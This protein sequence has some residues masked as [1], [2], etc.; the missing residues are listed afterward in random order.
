LKVDKV[1]FKLDEKILMDSRIHP[2]LVKKRPENSLILP[3]VEK[4][5]LDENLPEDRLFYNV[6]NSHLTKLRHIKNSTSRFKPSTA[7]ELLIDYSY[8]ERVSSIL[9][10]D[11]HIKSDHALINYSARSNSNYG[12]GMP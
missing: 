10:K 4:A 2:S 9:G 11:K 8:A 12:I 6:Y 5:D 1:K 7:R 3:S